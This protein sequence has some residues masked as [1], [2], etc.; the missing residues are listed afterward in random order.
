MGNL[1]RNGTM[2][3]CERCRKTKIKCD[4]S[5]PSCGR[6]L[7]KGLQCVYEAAPMTR[8]FRAARFDVHSGRVR[9]TTR[10][11]T[12]QTPMCLSG[13][14]QSVP[15]AG[16]YLSPPGPESRPEPSSPVLDISG[17]TLEVTPA[18]S[19]VQA[20]GFL[21]IGGQQPLTAD[22]RHI[23]R[24]MSQYYGSTGSPGTSMTAID[25]KKLNLGLQILD[26]VLEHS[27]LLRNL[28]HHIHGVI[29]MPMVPPKVM[30]P[31]AE[32][33]F[34]LL[35]SGVPPN[36]TNAK[37]RIV[38]RIFQSS[39]QPILD[40]TTQTTVDQVC[41]AITGD[42]L[43]WETLGN[44]LAM[45]SLCL[46]HIH[47]RDFILLDPAKRNK[48]DLIEPFHKITDTLTKLTSMSPVVNELGVCLRYNQLLLALYRFGD[49]SRFSCPRS[50]LV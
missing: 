20:G 45:A 44:V 33:L 48:Q 6:C 21:R 23:W 29:R 40:A 10:A 27:V 50:S 4:H 38:A 17:Q 11:E 26:F 2:Q 41:H 8:R 34:T 12:P 37:L 16:T 22:D 25:G 5:T 31:A 7:S 19:A 49:S 24:D 15:D 14:T 32:S 3:S 1:R 18:P 13:Q 28:T 35:T 43:R 39:C 36:D 46:I 42:N 9:T 30:L 47:D